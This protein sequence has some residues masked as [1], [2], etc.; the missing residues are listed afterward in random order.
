M[1]A[2]LAVC[3]GKLVPNVSVSPSFLFVML[4]A[5]RFSR[6]SHSVRLTSIVAT[7]SQRAYHAFHEDQAN[8]LPNPI[9]PQSAAFKVQ[10]VRF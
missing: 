2:Y 1:N 10:T 4:T 7:R 8:V 3:R 5:L 9:E 6:I